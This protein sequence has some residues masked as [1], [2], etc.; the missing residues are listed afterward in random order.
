MSVNSIQCQ[1][2]LEETVEAVRVGR[3]ERN[4]YLL[5]EAEH[6]EVYR[7]ALELEDGCG[8]TA[9]RGVLVDEH[10]VARRS[11]MSWEDIA[12]DAQQVDFNSNVDYGLDEDCEQI[13]AA[14]YRIW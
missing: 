12:E 10:P 8:V 9:V 4:G 3:D 5:C 13:E 6:N 14:S 11:K 7:Y 2:E 1:N